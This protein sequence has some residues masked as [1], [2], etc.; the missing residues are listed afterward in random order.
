[1]DVTVPGEIEQAIDRLLASGR[2]RS[3]DEVIS[4]AVRRLER[5]EVELGNAEAFPP[6]SL[7]ETLTPERN[8]EELALLKGTLLVPE[9]E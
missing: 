4:A 2:F 7:N 8:S 5:E 1:M 6:G 3:A 9:D